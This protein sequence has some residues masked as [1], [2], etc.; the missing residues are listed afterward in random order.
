MGLQTCNIQSTL[1]HH[2][3][4]ILSPYLCTN[5]TDYAP[6]VNKNISHKKNNKIGAYI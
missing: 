1:Y 5:R 4:K 6:F 2:A 3:G